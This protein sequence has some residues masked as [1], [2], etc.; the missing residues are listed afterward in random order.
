MPN[1]RLQLVRR[2]AQL[3]G[4]HAIPV[5][6]GPAT[7]PV[8]LADQAVHGH[9]VADDEPGLGLSHQPGPQ[10]RV[11][12]QHRGQ[13]RRQAHHVDAIRQFQHHALG[14]R[15][16]I[17]AQFEDVPRDGGQ[18][19]PP[20]GTAVELFQGRAADAGGHSG[21]LGEPCNGPALEHLPG[22]DLDPGGPR[23]DRYLD[24]PD[25]LATHRKEVVVGT[26]PVQ[27]EHLGVDPSEGH[28]RRR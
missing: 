3:S 2:G 4:Q 21:H 28:L 27:A 12:A 14:E 8:G 5:G 20:Q 18:R 22:C 13:G 24:G 1:R 19:H 10:H 25:A 23:A 6:A 26:D 9:G 15:V 11:V 16:A 7:I 17:S